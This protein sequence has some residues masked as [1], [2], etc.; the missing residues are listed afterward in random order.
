MKFNKDYLFT[1]ICCSTLFFNLQAQSPGEAFTEGFNIAVDQ[2]YQCITDQQRELSNQ[3]ISES[4]QNLKDQGKLFYNE[5]AKPDYIQFGWPIKQSE[6]VDYNQ[7]WAIS[8]YVDHQSGAGIKDYFCKERTYDGHQ[9]TD[10]FLWPFW[11]YAM[12]HN[13]AEIVAAADGQILYKFDGNYD[14][15]CV[16]GSGDWNAVYV[17]HADGSI[18]WYGHMKTGSLT[19][20]NVG[21]MVSKGEFLG[22]VG[23]SGSSS[24]PHLHFEIYDSDN[25]LIDPFEGSCNLLNTESWWEEQIPHDKP[26]INAVLTHSAYPVFPDCPEQEVTNLKDHFEIGESIYLAVYLTNQEAGST[27]HLKVTKPDG[28]ILNEWDETLTEYYQLSYSFWLVSSDMNGNWKWEVTYKGVTVVHDYYVGVMGTDENEI[29][30]FT[31]FPNPVYDHINLQ[32]SNKIV[33]VQIIDAQGKTVKHISRLSGIDQVDVKSLPAGF[34][35]IK[36]SDIQ[37]KTSTIKFMKK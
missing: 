9:G 36:A 33:D 12:D 7:V 35:V 3:M 28:T 11:W 32:S 14:R 24:G 4:I 29:K 22:F 26:T 23:S 16:M 17:Q 5:A 20:K 21:D 8:N 18:A 25:Q 2:G 30:D 6:G 10:F 1:A 13:Q 34:Y 27:M 15:S 19:T 31:V 37:K